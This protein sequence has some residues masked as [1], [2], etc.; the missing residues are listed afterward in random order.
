MDEVQILPGCIGAHSSA[1]I[2]ERPSG[3]FG[4]DGIHPIE[5]RLSSRLHLRLTEKQRLPE[6]LPP[7]AQIVCTDLKGNVGYGPVMIEDKLACER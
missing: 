5:A 7:G 4:E 1:Y 3:Q 6:R 2:G